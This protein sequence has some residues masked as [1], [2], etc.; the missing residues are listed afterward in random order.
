MDIL[1]RNIE[2]K[3]INEIDKKCE[4]IGKKLGRKYS[5]TE[6]IQS[7]IRHDSEKELLQFK[8]DQFDQ[9]IN[10]LSITL[11]RQAEQLQEYVNINGQ[12][13]ST[14]LEKV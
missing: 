12:L 5:R 11:E 8:Q 9:A 3:F 10:N 4:V 7:L 6:Y 14:L 13:I 1:V 2:P